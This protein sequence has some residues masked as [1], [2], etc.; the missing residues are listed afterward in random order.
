[1]PLVVIVT[2]ND[3]FSKFVTFKH[4]EYQDV[5]FQSFVSISQPDCKTKN[6]TIKA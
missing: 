4:S 5:G 3:A 1:M 2:N 6:S